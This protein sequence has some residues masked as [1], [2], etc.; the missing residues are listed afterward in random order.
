LS[1]PQPFQLSKVFVSEYSQDFMTLLLQLPQNIPPP[2]DDGTCNHLVGWTLPNLTLISTANETINLE[3]LQGRLVIYCYP[4]TGRP[5]VALPK[6]WNE[7]PGARGCT[8]QSCSFRDHYKELQS[9]NT[10]VFGLSTQ[11]TEYQKEAK[12]RLHLPFDL[13]S[14]CNLMFQKAFN[15]PTMIVGDMI[16]LKRVTLIFNNGTLVK[17]FYPVFPPD[18]H[19]EDVLDWLK[20]H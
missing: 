13:L 3:T 20:T 9:L 17:Y 19:I 14:D 6:G 2:C 11:T 4:M 12:V 1:Y 8:P 18:K 7:I 10:Q 16:L 5:D 15:L